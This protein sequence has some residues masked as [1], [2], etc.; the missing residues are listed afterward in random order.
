VAVAAHGA[1]TGCRVGQAPLHGSGKRSCADGQPP[2]AT[3]QNRARL[4]AHRA[5]SG[6]L[7]S[8]DGQR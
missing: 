8:M 1:I 3:V 4:P 2:G 5:L 6:R 7:W